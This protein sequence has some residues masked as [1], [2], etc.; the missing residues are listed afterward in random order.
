MIGATQ[1]S[2]VGAIRQRLNEARVIALQLCGRFGSGKT[3]LVEHLA[4]SL[5]N[6]EGV[7]I[8]SP[9]LPAASAPVATTD[10]VGVWY[11][12]G[13]SHFT[14]EIFLHLLD[15]LPLHALDFLFLEENR[16]PTCTPPRVLGCHARGLLFPVTGGLHQVEEAAEAI[17]RSHF[18]L[19]THGDRRDEAAFDVDAARVTIG[20]INDT[21]PV[22]LLSHTEHSEWME[23]LAYL[24]GLRR[25]HHQ[26]KVVTEPSPEFYFG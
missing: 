25:E 9:A 5:Q 17:V 12:P 14:P 2:V 4:S 10:E 15:E 7:G 24:E 18:I 20:Q 11:A 3:S 1:G 19:L 8:L 23:W 22:F 21:I 26:T 16:D 6:L 13:V